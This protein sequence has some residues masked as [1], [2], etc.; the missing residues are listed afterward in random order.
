MKSKVFVLFMTLCCATVHRALGGGTQSLGT[1]TLTEVAPRV[2][3]PNGDMLND[4]IF[5]KFDDT[6]SGLPLESEVYDVQGA[7]V[8]DMT[9]NSNETALL[10]NGKD[11]SGKTVPSGIYIYSITLGGKR[12]TGTVVVAK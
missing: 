10:W 11:S 9:L 2:V 12:A 1:V 8:S 5:F 7:K 4:V 3:T 6:V